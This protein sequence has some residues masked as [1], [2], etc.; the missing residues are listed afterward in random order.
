MKAFTQNLHIIMPMIV[1]LISSCGNGGQTSTFGKQISETDDPDQ[2][3]P[4]QTRAF[5][6]KSQ[7][8]H[9]QKT[10]LYYD[11]AKELAHAHLFSGGL[12][13]D[14]GTFARN[15]YTLGDW[16]T[17]WRG[18]Y[19]DNE[20]TFSYLS[21]NTGRVFFSR[22]HDV[23]EGEGEITVHAKAIGSKSGR[24]YL[25]G[26]MLGTAKFS[27]ES[28]EHFSVKF[29]V[30]LLKETNELLF[31]FN[32]KRKAHD[33]KLASLAVDY[34]RIIPPGQSKGPSAATVSTVLLPST[35]GGNPG[36][37]L[38]SGESLTYYVPVPEKGQITAELVSRTSGITCE[39]EVRVLNDAGESTV[40]SKVLL[41]QKT[42]R[43]NISLD[44]Y[45]GQNIAVSFVVTVGEVAFKNAGIIA[46]IRKGEKAPGKFSAK[47]V[48]LVLIDTLRADHLQMY[49]PDTRV[50]T[51][52][53]N[54][55][56]KE[57]MVFSRALAQENW[58]KPS[59]TTL[60]TGLYA[61]SHNTK[62]EK[63]KVPQTV[64][65][66]A[67]HF[68]RIGFATAGFVANGYISNKFGFKRGW[69]K[70]RNYVRE[71]RP[72][73]AQFVADDAVQW[74]K[75]RPKNKPFFLYVHTI[76]PHV[77][78]IPP[79]KYRALYD[80]EPYN[81]IVT[82]RGTPKLLE[83][84]KTGSLKLSARDKIRLEALYDG[85]IT[86]H[87]DHL[88]RVH[89]ELEAQ[90]LL[91]NTIIVVTADHGE[92][93]FDH[94]LVGHGHSMYEEL[95][96]VPLIIRLPG[97]KSD[98]V[99]K[100]P[101]E[102]GLVDVMPTLCEV[103]GVEC[104][105]EV[106]GR[107]LVKLLGGASGDEWPEVEFSDFLMGQ[108]VARADRYKLIYRGMSTTLFD[109]ETDPK[110][111]T[112]LCDKLPITLTLMRE[113]LGEHQGLF[114][115]GGSVDAAPVKK[116]HKKEKAKIDKETRKQLEA[117]GYFKH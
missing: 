55:L 6:H 71:G 14:F 103:L 112:D 100:C 52:Y 53:L 26:K 104:P 113:L 8:K 38:S 73:R 77:P 48:V 63:D 83:R 22:F 81:G 108:R 34:V 106:E 93:L 32:T 28:F 101:A 40:A 66:A 68:K 56:A 1:L 21:G 54:H 62:T 18:N 114:V 91:E 33:G 74:L 69:D 57:S 97:A 110:E 65:L 41:K 2:S 24:I 4:V 50:R 116:V 7:S 35:V 94:G 13:V 45:A 107:S 115:P 20:T 82:P 43:L 90:G 111:T 17:G 19:R 117:L 10:E 92:E 12:L 58:T 64:T 75:E 16:K 72:N 60:L 109:L 46:P 79:R 84:I 31:R 76:D 5:I 88:K 9:A 27:K 96:H 99:T 30:G 59:V 80:N 86:Y 85:E 98:S 36:F 39:V 78:Y 47:N 3:R 29:D 70:W 37:A 42:A 51:D 89:D 11:F 105:K 44:K 87:D 95:I 49:N 25:N 15:K 67:E 61:E 102:V 23:T